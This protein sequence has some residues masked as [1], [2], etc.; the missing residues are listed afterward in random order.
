MSTYIIPYAFRLHGTLDIDALQGALTEIVRRHEALRTRFS[1]V[2][3]EPMQEVSPSSPVPLPVDDLGGLPEHERE[4]EAVRRTGEEGHRGFDLERGPLIRCRLLKISPLDHLLL[5]TFHHIVFDG[6]S[7]GIFFRELRTLYSSRSAG[8][9][10][11]LAEPGLQYPDFALWQRRAL[12]GED[13]SKRLAYWKRTLAGAPPLL[14]LPT[15][16]PRPAVQRNQ[17]GERTIALPPELSRA[18][19]EMSRKEQMTL[20]MT[21]LAAFNVLLHRYSAQDD[22]LVGTPVAG[23]TYPGTEEVI[24][25]FVNT[26]VL[27]TDC[28]GDPSFRQLLMRVREAVLGAF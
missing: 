25:F 13:F 4:S 26:L 3:G 17:G 5:L 7:D 19:E 27:R 10:A 21:L 23:R 24:G 12:E 20:F 16:L 28:C 1:I 15:D 11:P 9:A 2:A 14:D 18:L 22:I 6:W 8:G